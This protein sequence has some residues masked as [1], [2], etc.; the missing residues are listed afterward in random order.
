MPTELREALNAAY[1]EGNKDENTPEVVE[2]NTGSSSEPQ[3]QL[4]A[5][6][7]NAEPSTDD[8]DVQPAAEGGDATKSTAEKPTVA[9][10]K[11]PE[12]GAGTHRVDRAPASWK[13]EAKGEWASVPLHIRQEVHKREMEV[14]R[15]LNETA[16]IRQEVQQFREVITPYMARIQSLGVT[17]H[18]AVGEL[19]KADYSLATGSPQ[20][21]AQFI[22][23]LLQDYNVD[24]AELDAA[25]SRRLGGQPSAQVNAPQFDPNQIS[26]LVQQQLQQ[27]LAP[28][29]QQ[30]QQQEE[31]VRQ[32]AAM[33]V[34]QMALDPQYP[35]F[36]EVRQDMADIVQL[37]AQRGIAITLQQAYTMAVAQNPEL[38]AM[39]QATQLNQRAQRAA[40]AAV[41]VSGAPVSGGTQA[42]VTT[43]DL[44]A[45]LEA[46]FGGNRI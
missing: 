2:K 1:E 31:Q 35:H 10:E 16:P 8:K 13:K 9:V 29:Y 27:A 24:I 17:P 20:Q 3:E 38:S 26:Q 14:Q 30:R 19:L 45:D 25:I 41:S 43:G 33:T 18:Q 11:Q 12:A 5:E 42:H 39:Q 28:I 36:D 22:D 40:A 6:D 21:K 23:K 37:K 15:V 46:A 44:R 34:E 7:S 4:P 32:Q